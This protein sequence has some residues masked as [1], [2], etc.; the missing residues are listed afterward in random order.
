VH[1]AVFLRERVAV[2]A[3]FIR[4]ALDLVEEL[5]PLLVRQTAA[6]PVG[7]GILPAMV[8]ET[9]VVVLLLERFDGGLDEVV[10]T[11]EQLLDVLGNFE[12]HGAPSAVGAASG[13]E[14]A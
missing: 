12:V 14:C 8:E 4:Q 6:V 11:V 9:D 1:A 3:G 10:E 5:L 7:A 13:R 2:E